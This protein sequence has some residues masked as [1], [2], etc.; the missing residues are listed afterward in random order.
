MDSFPKPLRMNTEY[1][2]DLF[3][4]DQDTFNFEATQ[5]KRGRSQLTMKVFE[6]SQF[7]KGTIPKNMSRMNSVSRIDIRNLARST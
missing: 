4:E 6:P 7:N 2:L 1:D 5:A 3:S